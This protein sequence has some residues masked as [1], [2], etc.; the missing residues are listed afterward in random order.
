MRH[1]LPAVTAACALAGPSGTSHARPGLHPL[2]VSTWD[3]TA[4]SVTFSGSL[5]LTRRGR[6][7]TLSNYSNFSSS[8]GDTSVQFG[9]HYVRLDPPEDSGF[10]RHGAAG[11]ATILHKTTFGERHATGL[12]KFAL[13]SYFG[14]APTALVGGGQNEAWFPFNVG[15]GLAWSPV[16]SLTLTPWVELAIGVS[17]DNV[18]SP[19]DVTL[20]ADQ[21]VDPATQQVS[22]TAGDVLAALDQAVTNEVAVAT[23]AR[24]GLTLALHLGG[25]VDLN[26]IAAFSHLGGDFGG[27]MVST[28]AGQLQFHWDDTMA[29]VLP[30]VKCPAAPP[31]PSCP[32]C[33]PAP[34]CPAA[35]PCP[36]APPCPAEAMAAPAPAP[37]PSPETPPLAAPTPTP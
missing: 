19:D 12:P 7:D 24:A 30:S 28:F 10:I 25:I 3:A 37:A 33:P 2:A 9:I 32:S 16:P 29:A 27:P 35:T 5:G 36:S 21:F 8:S 23:A 14:I 4:S 11:T 31:C 1:I 18:I 20:D 22:L 34:P 15:A 17:L 13:G 6:L 26:F